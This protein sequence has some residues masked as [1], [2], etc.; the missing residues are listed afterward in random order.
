[1]LRG[2]A[3]RKKLPVPVKRS[4]ASALSITAVFQAP[5]MAE[6]SSSNYDY[7][8]AVRRAREHSLMSDAT[9]QLFKVRLALVLPR[10]LGSPC[11]TGRAHRRLGRWQI[12]SPLFACESESSCQHV[13]A[14]L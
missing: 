8:S 6:Q 1:M 9:L 13:G 12:A 10:A 11:R 5:A 7:A 4:L 14:S 2:R 3:G